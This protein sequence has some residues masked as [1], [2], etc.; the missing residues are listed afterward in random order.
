MQLPNEVDVTPHW[1]GMF[2]FAVQLVKD[3]LSEEEGQAL[4][5]EML[6]F[7]ARLEAQARPRN[8]VKGE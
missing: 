2:R 4:V 5:V 1:P 3:G 8:P 6:E 7:G